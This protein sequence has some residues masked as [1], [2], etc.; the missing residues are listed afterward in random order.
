[1]S[2]IQRIA[3]IVIALYLLLV[4]LDRF[5]L[6]ELLVRRVGLSVLLA[7]LEAFATVGVADHDC[8]WHLL[9]QVSVVN[10]AG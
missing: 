6:V 2:K 7:L 8:A 1:M 4:L 10:A 3:S 9:D 5:V